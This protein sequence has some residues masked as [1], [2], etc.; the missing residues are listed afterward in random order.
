LNS[1]YEDL[2]LSLL[3]QNKKY[4]T[5]LNVA[6]YSV[7]LKLYPTV[8]QK[9]VIDITVGCA[10]FIYN[11]MLAERIEVYENLKNDR[12]ALFSHKY[13]T[14]KEYKE[15]F[16]FL[17]ESSSRGLQQSRLD[18]E[19]AY[20]NFYKRLKKG[21]VGKDAGFPKF[22]KKSKSKWTYREPQVKGSVM[23]IDISGNRLKLNKL[24]WVK[25]RGLNGRDDGNIK[26]V[27]VEKGKDGNYYA[28]ILF[29]V[30]RQK[31]KLRTGNEITGMDLGLKDFVSLSSGEVIG[32]V[33][34]R[35]KKIDKKIDKA[36]KHLSRK[37]N[38]SNRYEQQRIKLNRLYKKR[39]NIQNHFFWHLANKILCNSQAVA[40]ENLNVSGMKKNR[41][42][43]K[44]IHHVSW[45]GFIEKLKQKSVEYGTEVFVVDRFF[46]S[47]KLCPSCG[48][49]KQDLKLS[50]RVYK[51][52]CGY[53]QHRDIHSAIN[54]RNEFCN[55]YSISSEYGDYRH[56]E[57][58]RPKIVEFDLK[59]SFVEMPTKIIE[60]CA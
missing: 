5:I 35:L 34:K 38:G 43:S 8:K 7:K 36:N 40:I 28:S 12:D 32:G 22:K 46:P 24:G 53:E 6:H 15:E 10:R 30:D 56:G 45:Y 27:T 59:G 50:D 39:T 48:Q 4:A 31:R 13:K 37:K 47:S 29:E 23:A 17:K 58:V 52:D 54:L 55:A 42:L 20:R 44:V 41:K 16:P 19:A 26:S 60:L 3:T 1:T 33:H 51:C 25:F 49:I 9:K 57:T 21:K 11:Q 14:E 18:L 2:F